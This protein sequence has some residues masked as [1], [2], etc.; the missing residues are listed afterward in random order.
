MQAMVNKINAQDTGVKASIVEN[1]ENNTVSL[2]LTSTKTGQQDGAFTVN[3]TSAADSSN[4]TKASM[5]AQYSVN[6]VDS[7]SQSNDVKL[8]DGVT[9]TLNKTGSTEITYSPD[10][11]SAVNSVQSFI[12]TFNSLK[13]AASGSKAL[14]A[15]LN[16]VASN[17]SRS[18]SYSGIGM[19][20]NGKMSITNENTLKTA[21]S[22]GSFS[23]NFQGVNSFG[24]RLN[25]VSRNAYRTAYDSAVQQSFKQLM[26]NMVNTNN[27]ANN[28]WQQ[29]NTSL[30]S[31][32]LF[33]MLI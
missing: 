17:F 12:N 16:S 18:L 5:N 11:S 31:G 32:L 4:V 25:D 8:I 30:T 6:G 13:D 19:D 24:N 21:I 29:T 14:T 22:D 7:T 27:N 26:D 3:D 2:Q 28:W 15:Q 23:K 9:A 33:N 10:I 20:S 1:K